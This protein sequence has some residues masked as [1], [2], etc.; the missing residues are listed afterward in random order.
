M[1]RLL[2]SMI[3]ILLCLLGIV[4]AQQER[5]TPSKNWYEIIV[6]PEDI[7]F[8]DPVYVGVRIKNIS[9][10]PIDWI[11]NGWWGKM[12]WITLRSYNISAPYYLLVED[13][14]WADRHLAHLFIHNFQPGESMFV[15]T[16]YQELPSLEDMDLPFWKEAKERLKTGESIAAH[17]TLEYARVASYGKEGVNKNW[18]DTVFMSN[19]IR[20]KPRPDVEMKILKRW[21]EKTPEKLLPVPLDR[22]G[23]ER[24]LDESINLRDTDDTYSLPHDPDFVSQER[25][26]KISRSP[27]AVRLSSKEHFI[28]IKNKDYLPNGFLR[29]GNRK[30]GDPVCP[31][32]WQGWKELEESLLPSTMRDEIRLTRLLIQY[33]DTEDKAVLKELKNWFHDMNHIQRTSMAEHILERWAAQ[34]L[35]SSFR[36]FYS[37]IHEY[38][39]TPRHEKEIEWLKKLGRIEYE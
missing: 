3:A 2:L 6:Y 17:I 33:C 34:D 30:P 31:T 16:A 20:I 15:F 25:I 9:D 29:I 22:M 27:A 12:F 4:E 26:L 35:E 28:K 13:D 36:N 11:I 21:L 18:P 7:Y 1:K 8:G 24:I 19:P 10:K 5:S 37:T 32:T 39:E 38:N 14:W 23:K